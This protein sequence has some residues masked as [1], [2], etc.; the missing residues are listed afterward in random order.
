MTDRVIRVTQAV[1]RPINE[2]AVVSAGLVSRR[3]RRV[4]HCLKLDTIDARLFDRDNTRGVGRVGVR[5]GIRDGSPCIARRGR[6]ARVWVY[7]VPRAGSSA[8]V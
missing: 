2:R 6:P 4:R 8:V 7:V 1:Y 3:H 5:V